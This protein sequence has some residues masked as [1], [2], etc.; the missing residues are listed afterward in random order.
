MC[1]HRRTAAVLYQVDNL[2][3]L[4]PVVGNIGRL[5]LFQK[6][7]KSICHSVKIPL[8]HHGLSNMGTADRS[9]AIGNFQHIGLVYL[10]TQAL[11]F[12]NHCRKPGPAP[13]NHIV[14]P[15]PQLLVVYVDVVA[16]NVNLT[17]FMMGT[18]LYARNNPYA[19]LGIKPLLIEL[20]QSCHRIVIR[21]SNIAKPGFLGSLHQLL[22]SQQAVR[23]AGV[24][25]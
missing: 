18:K 2:P 20:V 10:V 13:L 4:Q 6:L 5:A 9:A 16:E 15:V 8:L 19:R 24:G 21:N 1:Q 7:G 14:E 12:L 17:G 25:M 3:R 23:T 22:R 11:Q